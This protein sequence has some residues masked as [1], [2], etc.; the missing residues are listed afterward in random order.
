MKKRI[1]ITLTAMMMMSLAACGTKDASSD[2]K[3]KAG[4]Y[5]G[6]A[7][8]FGGEIKATVT[9][10]GD[11]IDKIEVTGDKET[12]GIGSV[13]VEKL[14]AKMVETQT[15]KV[16]GVSGASVSSAAVITA[17]TS[18][19]ETAGVDVSK[20]EAIEAEK[21]EAQKET[22]DVD[23]VIVGAGGAGM[24]AALEA[25]A[26]G[27]NVIIIEKAAYAGGNTS[28]ATGGM[29]AAET[30]T[31]KELGV[32]DTIEQFVEDTMAGGYNKNNIKLVT[33]MCEESSAAIDWLEEI[34]APLSDLSFSG[35]ATNKRIHRPEDG[36]GV[37]AFLVKAYT[38]N[39]EEQK[40]PVYYDTEATKILTNDKGAA[41]G[42]EAHSEDTNYTI[43]AKSVIL[44]TGG[45]GANEE[46]Y[47]KYR[48]ELKGYV[49]TNVSTI[50]GDGITMATDIG[51]NTVDMEQI[52]IHPTVEQKTSLLITES[53]RGD[54]AILVNKSGV[55]FGDELRTRDVVSAA[56]I[57]QEESYAY[58]V[59][60][61]QL[62]DELSAVEKYIDNHIV[63][64]ADSIEELATKLGLDSKTL[65]N[66]VSTWNKAVKSKNDAEFGRDTGMEHDISV[67]PFYAIKIAPGVHHTMGGVE[68]NV[69]AEVIS[70]DGKA[71]PGLFAAGEVCGGIH[72]GNRIGGTAVTDIVVFGR[73]AGTSAAQYNATVK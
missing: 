72:G 43:N 17:V 55:R 37:G 8:G 61:Q 50:T 66:T 41:V 46:L 25:K 33:K 13:A 15:V 29:N 54:G 7:N 63:E 32:N 68:I 73:I 9:L 16:D 31:Q 22:L 3:F 18:A 4:T 67:G 24:T 23:T 57:E 59:F 47:T 36:S 27:Q 62:R 5:E 53:V 10:S 34:G 58:L 30:K 60:D 21:K 19:L 14:P 1:A 48:P 45:F 6:T 51:A 11:K 28:R 52:Q 12:Q 26:A 69:N 65:A 49:T 44:A 39:I 42:I 35:G 20:L 2:S 70:T 64:Q 40:I 71:I 56:I 38:K